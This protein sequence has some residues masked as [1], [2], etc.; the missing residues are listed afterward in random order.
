MLAND[1]YEAEE[2]EEWEGE[3]FIYAFK[4]ISYWKKNL[5]LQFVEYQTPPNI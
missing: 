5:C 4:R 1:N 3:N 2:E